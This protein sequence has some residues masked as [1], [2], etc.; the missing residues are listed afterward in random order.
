MKSHAVVTATGPDR[1]GIVDDLTTII[2]EGHCN[3]EESRMA[4]LGGEF[5]VILLLSGTADEVAALIR[6]MPAKGPDLGLQISLKETLPAKPAPQSRPYLLESVSLD[7]PGIVHSI[8]T[9]LRRHGVNINDLE[10]ET[11]PAPWTGAPM[12]VMKAR[13]TVPGGV[14]IAALRE[15]VETLEAE[16]NLDIKLTPISTVPVEF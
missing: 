16:Q 15:E 5:A 10:T 8:T 13:L 7:T 3:V 2:L 6:E 9:L 1:V 12:F 14:S 4:V 11:I